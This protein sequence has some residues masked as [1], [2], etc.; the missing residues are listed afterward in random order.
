MKFSPWDAVLIAWMLIGYVIWLPGMAMPRWY[1]A[2]CDR[3]GDRQM[4]IAFAI[5]MMICAWL[6]I[7][8]ISG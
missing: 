5:W 7:M 3:F 4:A 2:L 8:V 6:L 1:P